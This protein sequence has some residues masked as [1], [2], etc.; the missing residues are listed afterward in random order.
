MNYD[1]KNKHILLVEDNEGDI[2]LTM[3][4]LNEVNIGNNVKVVRDG[5]EAMQYLHKEGPFKDV[6]TPDIILLDINLPKIEGKEVLKSIKTNRGLMM[7]PVVM[8][9]TSNA[10][11]DIEECYHSHANCYITKPMDMGNFMEVIQVMKSF[12]LDTVQLPKAKSI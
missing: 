2:V 3:E 9:T 4:A 6:K 12:W 10:E 11:K 5:E 1:N 7:I 8:L